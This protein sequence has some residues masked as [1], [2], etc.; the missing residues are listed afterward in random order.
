MGRMGRIDQNAIGRATR[1]AHESAKSGGIAERGNVR[2]S[3]HRPAALFARRIV[4]WRPYHRTTNRVTGGEFGR[5]PTEGGLFFF[6]FL[7]LKLLLLLDRWRGSLR[8]NCS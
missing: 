7:R 4:I 3:I 2:D 1:R 8:L 6:F 5:P